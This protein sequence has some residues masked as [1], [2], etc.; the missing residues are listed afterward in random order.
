M[1]LLDLIILVIALIGFTL[2]YKDGFIRKLVGFIGFV[3][4]VYLSIIF[5][6]QLGK[7]IENA[8]EIEYYMAEL[9]AGAVIFILIIVTFAFVKRLIHPHDKVNNFVNQL[10]GGTIGMLQILFFISAALYILNV[11]N[12]PSNTSKKN[13]LIY[14]PV[15]SIIP[16][17]IDLVSNYT[18]DAK[19]RI[20]EYINEKDSLNNDST[21]TR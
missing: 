18:P 1:N 7:A 4:A 6:S 5:A 13:S 2:G 11:F 3:L 20:K 19:Q 9:I 16:V 14:K 12:V 21:D 17:T 15:Y 10:V 8:F